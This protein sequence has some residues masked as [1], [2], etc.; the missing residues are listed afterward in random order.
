LT[1]RESPGVA[2][3]SAPPLADT[4]TT[5]RHQRRRAIVVGAAEES[6]QNYYAQRNGASTSDAADKRGSMKT[7]KV[8]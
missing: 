2:I 1:A 8:L 7:G 4:P 3:R 6:E 5:P